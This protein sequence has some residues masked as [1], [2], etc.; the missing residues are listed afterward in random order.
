MELH[1]LE[2]DQPGTGGG[3]ERQA[4]AG[5]LGRIGGEAEELAEAA[6]REHDLRRPMQTTPAV[7]VAGENADDTGSP[8]CSSATT[9]SATKRLRRAAPSRRSATRTASARTSSA[10]VESPWAWRIR[11]RLCAASWPKSSSPRAERSNSAPSSIRR[12]TAVTPSRASSSAI[13]G[14]TSPAPAATVSAAWSSGESPAP[15]DTATPPWAQGLE[16]DCS[17]VLVSR[18][19]RRPS[20]AERAGEPRDAGADRR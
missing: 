14:S 15:I 13:T 3:S 8:S 9:S 10:P 4:V 6:G 1:E 20:S 19:T 5:R 2:V 12:R 18:S 16:P 17:V 11:R 7:R